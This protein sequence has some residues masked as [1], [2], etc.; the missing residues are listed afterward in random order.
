MRPTRGSASYVYFDE[1]PQIA[2]FCL[3][4]EKKEQGD[5]TTV[6]HSVDHSESEV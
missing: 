3:A 5:Q 1:R 6:F 4:F 2:T